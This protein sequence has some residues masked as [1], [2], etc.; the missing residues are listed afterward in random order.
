M[1]SLTKPNNLH[2]VDRSAGAGLNCQASTCFV[3]IQ[4]QKDLHS[5]I[6][7]NVRWPGIDLIRCPFPAVKRSR[8]LKRNQ[9]FWS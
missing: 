4:L 5:P 7:R 2:V 6:R 3:D 9:T 1:H 8:P